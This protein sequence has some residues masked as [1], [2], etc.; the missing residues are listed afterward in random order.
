MPGRA[1]YCAE[2]GRHL[3]TIAESAVLRPG[4]AFL[5]AEHERRRKAMRQALRL[6]HIKPETLKELLA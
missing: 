2:C 6:K 1:I 5:C 3:G 4:T